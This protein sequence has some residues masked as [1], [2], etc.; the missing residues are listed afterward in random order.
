VL[1][2]NAGCCITVV[3]HDEKANERI[4]DYKKISANLD[5]PKII[6]KKSNG[7]PLLA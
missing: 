6:S 2:L 4:E 5:L 1:R 3:A 7:T